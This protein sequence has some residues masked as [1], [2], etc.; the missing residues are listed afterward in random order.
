M[1]KATSA[2]PEGIYVELV[3]SLFAT[4]MP[5]VI[6]SVS[7]LGIGVL[8]DIQTGDTPLIALTGFGDAAVVSRL[9]VILIYRREAETEAISARR[10]HGL[11]RRFASAY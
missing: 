8:L 6:M 2:L 1:E 4:L 5:T 9:A 10:A 11:E 3:R 7:F